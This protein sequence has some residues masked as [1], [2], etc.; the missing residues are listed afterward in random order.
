MRSVLASLDRVSGDLEE[1]ARV[2]GAGQWRRFKDIVLP[3]IKP[4]IVLGWFLVLI[5]TMHE[6]TV[7][8]L[9][10]SVGNE[11]LGVAVFTLQESGGIQSTAALALVTIALTSILRWISGKIGG[12]ERE[13]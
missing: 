11:T 6:L 5:P 3:V 8:V 12:K 1:A 2:S 10:W 7:S 4:G 9:L 13:L